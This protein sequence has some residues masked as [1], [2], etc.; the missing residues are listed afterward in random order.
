[1]AKAI[2][3]S[4]TCGNCKASVQ[5]YGRLVAENHSFYVNLCQSCLD[6]IKVHENMACLDDNDNDNNNNWRQEEIVKEE[7]IIAEDGE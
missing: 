1:M 3:E 7:E 6:K 5:L 4:V 2:I